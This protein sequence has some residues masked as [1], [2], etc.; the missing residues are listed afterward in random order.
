MAEIK[1]LKDLVLNKFLDGEM[2]V[3]QG[4]D[5]MVEDLRIMYSFSGEE[6]RARG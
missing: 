4:F 5:I 3:I 1:Q 6:S 2:L